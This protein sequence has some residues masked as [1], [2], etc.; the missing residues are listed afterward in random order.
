MTDASVF[1][2]S[3]RVQSDAHGPGACPARGGAGSRRVCRS[4]TGS[5]SFRR[6]A[7]IRRRWSDGESSERKSGASASAGRAFVG[8]S[9]ALEH[10][11]PRFGGSCRVDPRL[12]LNV[13][14]S[15]DSVFRRRLHELLQRQRDHQLRQRGDEP[16]R[17]ALPRASIGLGDG[18]LRNSPRFGRRCRRPAFAAPRSRS[19]RRVRLG[20]C[21]KPL[22]RISGHHLGLRAQSPL[23]HLRRPLHGEHR[24]VGRRRDPGIAASRSGPKASGALARGAQPS[25]VG[26]GGGRHRHRRLRRLGMARRADSAHPRAGLPLEPAILR[27]VHGPADHRHS[28]RRRLLR[29][30]PRTRRS[31]SSNSPTSSVLIVRRPTSR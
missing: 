6:P 27:L 19:S 16:L 5:N 18:L 31:S 11:A 14:P 10:V 24:R 12:G 20:R 26:D 3:P 1:P 13:G 17:F 29:R 23:S 30:A 2:T 7:R 8:G 25:G 9:S 22:F 4:E 15:P 28:N 21:G